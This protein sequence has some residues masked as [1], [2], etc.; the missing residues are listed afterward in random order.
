M[1]ILRDIFHDTS[2]RFHPAL[3]LSQVISDRSRRT[4]QLILGVLTLFSLVV[5]VF[6]YIRMLGGVMVVKDPL[7]FI[8]A[9]PSFLA[10]GGVHVSFFGVFVIVF[11][12]WFFILMLG[13]FRNSYYYHVEAL[14]ERGQTGAKTKYT[15]PNYETNDIFFHTVDGDL[16]KSFLSSPY[17]KEIALRSGLSENDIE[18]YFRTRTVT[19]DFRAFPA[20]EAVFTLKDIAGSVLLGDSAFAAFVFAHS[21]RPEDI[22]AASEWVERRIKQSR[23]KQRTWGRVA[24]GKTRGIGS[25]LSYG[26][27][28]ALEKYS[29]DLT[30]N[31]SHSRSEF[32]HLYGTDAILKMETILARGA[33]ANVVLVGGEGGALMDVV[34]D[35]THDVYNGF[36]H[37]AF[38]GVHIMLLDWKRLLSGM[39]TKQEFELRVLKMMNSAVHAKNI[40]I[41]IDDLPGFSLSASALGSDVVS[42]LD[43]YAQSGGVQFIAT[44]DVGRYH[45]MLEQNGAFRARFET[46]MISEPEKSALTRTLEDAAAPLEH[47]NGVI[48][49]YPAVR[50]IRDGSQRYFVDAVM[51]DTALMLMGEL[52]SIVS[53]RKD[54]SVGYDDVM[55]Y[56]QAKT[57]IPV[58]TITD[59]ERKKLE[60]LEQELHL[61]VVGQEKALQV[62]A[63]ALRRSRAGV[64][65]P[66]RPI[67]TFLFLGPTGVGKTEAAKALARVFFGAESAMVRFDMSEFQSEDGLARLIGSIGTGAGI[68]SN[69][70]REHPY[71]V[72]LL[73][74]FEKTHPKVLD[75]FLQIFDEGI[76]HDAGG[77]KVNAQ[78][79]IMIATSNAGATLIRDAVRQGIPLE[80]IEKNIIDGVIAEGKY[81]PELLNRFDAL[82]LFHPLTR[83]DYRQVAVLMVEKL[84]KRLREQ[85]IDI[86]INDVLIDALLAKGVDP[87]FGARP[88]NRAV[89]ELVEQTIAKKIISGEV[90]PGMTVTFSPADFP[91]VFPV[92]PV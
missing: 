85:N 40:L 8:N 75:L 28:Y 43:P 47:M 9:L 6:F 70:L 60:H 25:D 55:N 19:V 23:R 83:E 56:I 39:K 62:I 74:E 50:A 87:D 52:A 91:E 53:S 13:W 21:V 10:Q 46:L 17:G 38:A 48:F 92:S 69:Q 81:K 51:P 1:I 54:P 2:Y 49:T 15:T 58:G 89:Q 24:L 84:K 63:N 4:A 66:N 27:A 18:E 77:K 14:L 68:L 30:K 71:S 45:S 37:K 73:D 65:N 22:S 78:N 59:E 7:L 42:I 80:S 33:S 72:L 16:L 35:F 79:T 90:H 44:A 5:S 36:T 3:V 12:F 11:S 76:F 32:R 82:V 41:V 88:M 64:R 20:I 26:V 61:H 31:M 57:Q 29:T 34:I 86:A 67:G